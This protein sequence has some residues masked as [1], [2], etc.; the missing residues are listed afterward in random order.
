MPKLEWDKIGEKEYT[1][2]VSNTVV[3]PYDN[4]SSSYTGGFAWSGVTSIQVTPSGGESTKYYA[5]NTVYA[6]VLSDETASAT[7]ECYMTPP[8]F[9]KFDGKKSLANGVQITQQTRPMFGLSYVT[10]VGNDTDGIDHDEEIH[11]LY[12]CKASPS[13]RQSQTINENIDLS[14]MSFSISTEKVNVDG[15]SPTSHLVIRKSQV[16]AGKYQGVLDKLQG[17]DTEVASLPMPSEIAA[18]VS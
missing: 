15:S 12:G 9:D 14:T 11:V 6:T 2:G 1:L 13:E 16:A 10:K 7:V 3:Y 4:A 17:S 8:D 18:L 5:D